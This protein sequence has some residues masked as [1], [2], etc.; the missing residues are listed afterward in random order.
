MNPYATSLM[1]FVFSIISTLVVLALCKIRKFSPS[2]VVLAG[3]AIGSI[4]TALTT[5][6]QFYATDVGL[7]AAVIWNFGDL[8]RATYETD[9][10]MLV[11]V[12][13]GA[14]FFILNSLYKIFQTKKRCLI[15]IY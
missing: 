10:I 9:L 5:L 3:I 15:N 1:A 6:L 8:G 12:L 2:I 7:S 4:W 13:I 14:I 11:V